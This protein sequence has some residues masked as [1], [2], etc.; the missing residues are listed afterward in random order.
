MKIL[1]LTLFL[2][3][4]RILSAQ[5]ENSSIDSLLV[6]NYELDGFNMGANLDLNYDNTFRQKVSVWSCLGGG[7]IDEFV[8]KYLVSNNQIIFK[9]TYYIRSE[10]ID[11]KLSKKDSVEYNSSEHLFRDTFTII[12]WQNKIYLLGKENL[13]LW[14]FNS[15]N[16][17][18]EF[19]ND[20][21]SG[22]Y[23]HPNYG[24]YWQKECKCGTD[25]DLNTLIPEPW[26][27]LLVKE[28]IVTKT[29][30][31]ESYKSEREYEMIKSIITIDKGALDGVKINMKFYSD[32][33][34]DCACD[35]EIFEVN[36]ETSKGYA[37]I[38]GPD[39][40]QVGIQLSTY[41][42]REKVS[43]EYYKNK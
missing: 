38:C 3:T 16:D 43:I 10:Y 30:K 15:K 25:N 7:E 26:R 12:Q 39:D 27:D 32:Q 13:S 22:Y 28:I 41:L 36:D 4:S 24:S 37:Q 18:T 34:E 42:K 5:V 33:N 21:N 35:I 14:S 29:I 20:I 1:I 40:C 2:I 17:F 6:G 8:G 23:V 11:D 9:P 31:V 19:V